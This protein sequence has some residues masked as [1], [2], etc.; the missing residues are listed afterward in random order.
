MQFKAS[1]L[2]QINEAHGDGWKAKW[3]GRALSWLGDPLSSGQQHCLSIL[4]IGLP[5]FPSPGLQERL[6]FTEVKAKASFYI[7]FISF[8]TFWSRN[9]LFEFDVPFNKPVVSQIHNFLV[10]GL[11]SSLVGN[12]QGWGQVAQVHEPSYLRSPGKRIRN[13]KSAWVTEWVPG[14]LGQLGKNLS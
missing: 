13:S 7:V 14:Q 12:I 6:L 9:F 5:A 11:K 10:H 1:C 4:L 2:G 3:T 8:W